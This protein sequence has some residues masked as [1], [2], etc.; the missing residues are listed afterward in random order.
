MKLYEANMEKLEAKHKENNMYTYNQP[1]S[2]STTTTSP[3]DFI[4]SYDKCDFDTFNDYNK[5]SSIK[6]HASVCQNCKR[7][8]L[9]RNLIENLSCMDSNTKDT[10]RNNLQNEWRL[11][12]LIVSKKFFSSFY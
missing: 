3:V 12:A 10:I 7:K 6:E 8:Y 1:V 5:L 9:S 4:L 2:I 11:L